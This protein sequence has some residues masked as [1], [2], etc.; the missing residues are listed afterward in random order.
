MI[1]NDPYRNIYTPSL[2]GRGIGKEKHG[3]LPFVCLITVIIVLLV[4][5][6]FSK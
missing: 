5:L 6:S 3:I 1:N 2:N 4:L